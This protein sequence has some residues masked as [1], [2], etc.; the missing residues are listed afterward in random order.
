MIIGRARGRCDTLRG[1][2]NRHLELRREME[3]EEKV[4]APTNFLLLLRLGTF[5][6]TRWIPVALVTACHSNPG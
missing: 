4:A 1:Q 2:S 5:K 3:E 6:L